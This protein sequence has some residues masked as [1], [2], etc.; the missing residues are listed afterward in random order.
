MAA[1]VR[2]WIVEAGQMA[3]NQRSHRDDEWDTRFRVSEHVE[4]VGILLVREW[5]REPRGWVLVGIGRGEGDV[6]V[7][8]VIGVREP[9]W[10]VEVGEE[11]WRVAVEWGV[12]DG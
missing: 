3:H 5:G 4:D 11:K 9:I 8:R 2:D 10:D 7:G 12:V 1:T 6:E